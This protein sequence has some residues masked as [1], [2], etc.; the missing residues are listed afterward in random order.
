M[1]T[2]KV[3]DVRRRGLVN[4]SEFKEFWLHFLELWSQVLSNQVPKLD[5]DTL[6]LFFNEI[7]LGEDEFDFVK[8]TEAREKN[9]FV[10]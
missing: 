1:L 10:F 7:S 3:I 4:L 2:F 9:S 5:D 8:F 6:R